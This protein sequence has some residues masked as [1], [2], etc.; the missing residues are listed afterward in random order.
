[1]KLPPYTNQQKN[2]INLFYQFRY[3]KVLQLMKLLNHKDP[4]RIQAWLS[5]LVEKGYL[6]RIKVEEKQ[7]FIYCLDTK[8]KHILKLKENIDPAV[9]ERLHKEKRNESPFIQ[10]QI[11]ICDVYLYFLAQKTKKQNLNF[12]TSQELRGHED[13]PDP[14]PS[15]FIELIDGKETNR[16][17][18]EYFD[19]YTIHEIVRKRVQYYLDYCHDYI[20]Q[21]NTDEPFPSILFILPTLKFRSHIQYY[22]NA[23]F[24]KNLGDDIDLFLTTK[25]MI[26]NIIDN[27]DIWQKVE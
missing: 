21:T 5:D 7:Y 18:L 13:F 16:Y 8:A 19:E 11:F 4:R 27:Q 26:N 9:L 24:E 22:A 10:K 2:I 20:W 12:F 25:N 23:I 3:L 1:M 6:A 14:L 15:A 17:F